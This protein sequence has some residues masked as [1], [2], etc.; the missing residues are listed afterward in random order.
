MK[1]EVSIS[2][3]CTLNSF[4]IPIPTS[5]LPLPS[6]ICHCDSCRRSTGSLFNISLPLPNATS[7]SFPLGTTL[8]ASVDE[9]GKT[10]TRWFCVNC[11]AHMLRERVAADGSGGRE[12]VVR[13]GVVQGW[14]KLVKIEAHIFVGNTTDGG[15]ALLLPRLKG[16][17]EDLPLY[18]EG[19]GSDRII[20]PPPSPL[21]S[22]FLSSTSPLLVQC[23][24]KQVSLHLSR[25]S[26]SSTHL[27]H[28]SPS[29]SQLSSSDS[30][31]NPWWLTILPAHP[32]SHFMAKA[33]V[34][35]S[36]TTNSGT[37]F[38]PWSYVPLHLLS[39]SHSS[40]ST[41]SSTFVAPFDPRTL[42]A[43]QSFKN[44]NNP[45]DV[46]RFFCKGC[47]A[48]VFYTQERRAAL[49]DLAVGLFRAEEG[50]RAESWLEWEKAVGYVED[51]EESKGEVLEGLVE[52]M[53]DVGTGNST[54]EENRAT[55]VRKQIGTL[56]GLFVLFRSI[57]FIGH[58][59][60]QKLL[61]QPLYRHPSDDFYISFAD[62]SRVVVQPK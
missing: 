35:T 14:E 32:S 42:D 59:L 60:D 17:G 47:G 27:P 13:V 4:S 3:H 38:F 23:L 33:C 50:A 41:P 10:T 20:L 31:S 8:R 29:P 5:S 36:C 52:G 12:W 46:E 19:V 11:G 30:S 2:C 62:N 40:S 44:S 56:N 53:R 28:P 34:C 45:S 7:S 48:S 55:R 16:G 1:T 61:K 25:P 26:S 51:V 21:P 22:A 54:E 6:R 57:G 18:S 39:L 58:F 9:E 49:V 24:C 37:P 15:G 43:L